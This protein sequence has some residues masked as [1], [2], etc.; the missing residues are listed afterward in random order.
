MS[1]FLHYYGNFLRRTS[2]ATKKAVASVGAIYE[3]PLRFA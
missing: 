1:M 2:E 3:L